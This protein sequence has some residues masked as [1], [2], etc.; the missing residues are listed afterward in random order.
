MEKEKFYY[1]GEVSKIVELPAHIIRFWEKQLSF[2]KPL[3]DQK[4][5][6]IYTEKDIAKI[7]KIKFL[8]YNEG[9]KI[10]GVKRKL[11]ERTVKEE[12][13]EMKKFL[14]DILQEIQEIKKCLQ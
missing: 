3:R 14:Q 2:I 7:N 11:R 10:K 9:Y 8:V 5:H 12:T 1:I 13:K 4:G 6:R